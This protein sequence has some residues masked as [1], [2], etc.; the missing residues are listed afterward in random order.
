VA[1][2]FLQEFS[3]GPTL[4]SFRA[5]LGAPLG[6]WNRAQHFTYGEVLI[7]GVVKYI[8][9]FF[10]YAIVQHICGHQK[11]LT[12][13]GQLNQEFRREG[14]LHER[15]PACTCFRRCYHDMWIVPN[16]HLASIAREFAPSRIIHARQLANEGKYLLLDELL[17]EIDAAK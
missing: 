5:L 4:L 3:R 1:C 6:L 17:K 12:L 10:D 7:D 16:A 11:K 2:K 15:Q 9:A 14:R 13:K 8:L